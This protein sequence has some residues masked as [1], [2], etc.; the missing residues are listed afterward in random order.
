MVMHNT[1][2]DSIEVLNTNRYCPRRAIFFK[3]LSTN[4]SLYVGATKTT[5]NDCDFNL[6]N[7]FV[8]TICP[9]INL[10]NLD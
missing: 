1:Y 4:R 6:R 8:K 3:D 2:N 5:P 7:Y 9:L 10:A